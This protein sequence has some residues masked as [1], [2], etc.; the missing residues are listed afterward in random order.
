MAEPLTLLQQ[1]Y[2][3]DW[4]IGLDSQKFAD[5]ALAG[6][7]NL[8]S[9][10][11]P[12]RILL[13]EPDPVK[14]LAHF[15]AAWAADCPIALANPTWAEAEWQ[16]ALELLQPSLILGNR[17]A[18]VSSSQVSLESAP[19]ILIPTGGSSGKI[20]FA[21]HT[22]ASLMASVRGFQEF[23]Q[24]QQIHSCCLL[25]L[26]HVSGLMQFLRSFTS[27]GQLLVQ[28]FKQVEQRGQLPIDPSDFFLSLVPTQLQRLLASPFPLEQFKTV[29]LGGAPAWPDLLQ[30]A[31]NAGIRLA[32]T[33]GMTETAS[34]IATLK[35]AEFL[36]GR[37]GVGRVLPHASVTILDEAGNQ[38][39]P[40]AVGRVTIQA[41]SLALG[42]YPKRFEQPEFQP[43]DLG[44]LDSQGY[45]YIAGRQGDKIIT[46]GEN[47]F[48]AEVEAALRATGLVAD[49]CVV[50]VDDPLWGQIVTAIYVPGQPEP[51]IAA[52]KAAL[53]N[54]L[55]KFKHPKHWLAVS[56]I[57]RSPQG[58][59]NRE[60]LLSLAKLAQ[61]AD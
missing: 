10:D 21:S 31:R 19:L 2:S 15:V 38:M 45:L 51:S 54:S 28:P 5:L 34:Q 35:P 26:Y 25:P 22:W 60:Q 20:R 58:K 17:P 36:A 53:T 30:Q 3:Q 57:P 23:F 56:Q 61:P 7:T 47:V 37:S 39:P 43:D 9:Y 12:P 44:Y 14:F 48:P 52:L 18:P 24:V 8:R 42:Y 6:W 4:L 32:P 41:R 29:L 59:V 50:G 27:G 1:R 46:G 49:A 11:R 13:S 16:Q 40:G 55:S 33:Y